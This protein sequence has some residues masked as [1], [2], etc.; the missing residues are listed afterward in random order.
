MVPRTASTYLPNNR[1]FLLSR[2]LRGKKK[3][4][5]Q[6][7][8]KVKRKREGKG[9]VGQRVTEEE[10]REENKTRKV[11]SKMGEGRAGKKQNLPMNLEE[12]NGGEPRGMIVLFELI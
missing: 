9:H 1:K 7:C 12:R 11:K 10:T 2:G 3:A 4:R 8:S 6:S 5:G